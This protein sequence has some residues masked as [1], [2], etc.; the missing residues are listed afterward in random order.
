M[1]LSFESMRAPKATPITM[2]YEGQDLRLIYDRAACTMEITE[3][4]GAM[5]IRERVSKLLIGWDMLKAGVPWQPLPADDESWEKGIHADRLQ[6]ALAGRDAEHSLTEAERADLAAQPVT[7]EERRALYVAAWNT[8][9]LQ[10]PREFVRAVDAE[11]LDDFLG[12]IWRRRISA[13]G[14]APIASSAGSPGGMS[15]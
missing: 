4:I 2:V 5:G 15:S 12:V 10:L 7:F 9:L 11:I 6:R 8:I 1:P 14:S 13:N 3:N